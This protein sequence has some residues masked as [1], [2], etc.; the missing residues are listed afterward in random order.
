MNKGSVVNRNSQMD[1]L[2]YSIAKLTESE[3]NLLTHVPGLTVFKKTDAAKPI[4]GFYEPS[5]CLIAQ[6]A[7]HVQLGNENYTYDTEHYLFSGVH[8]L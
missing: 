6:G 2:A 4:A 3:G 7:K 5:V 8:L 1:G